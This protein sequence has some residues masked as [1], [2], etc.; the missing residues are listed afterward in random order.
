MLIAQQL[1]AA[2]DELPSL[3]Y[4]PSFRR[5]ELRVNIENSHSNNLCPPPVLI[6]N[7]SSVFPVITSLMGERRQEDIELGRD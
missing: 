3:D 1:Q 5:T 4:Q 2:A 7:I 6:G